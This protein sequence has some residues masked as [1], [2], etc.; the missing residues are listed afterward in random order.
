MIKETVLFLAL[1]AAS[2]CSQAFDW[3][4]PEITGRLWK[5]SKSGQ[6]DSY[7]LGTMHVGKTGSTLPPAVES[8]LKQSDLL[9]SEVELP[10]AADSAASEDMRNMQRE[11]FG[12]GGKTLSKHIGSSRTHALKTRW[13][14]RADT[15]AVLPHIE[16]LKP[17]AALLW[18]M[19]VRPAG[20]Q[21]E[22][23]LDFLLGQ[24]ALRLNIRRAGLERYTDLPQ[25]FKKLPLARIIEQLDLTEKYRREEEALQLEAVRLYEQKRYPEM[26]RLLGDTGRYRRYGVPGHTAAFW[27]NWFEHNIL[28]ARNRKW[29]PKILGSLPGQK[30]LIAVGSAH[31]AGQSGLIFQLRKHGYTVTPVAE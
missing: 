19:N 26:L 28:T 23:G 5:I 8:V 10:P 20:Y 27:Q 17:W 30:T 22:Y 15:R 29:L 25:S 6:P 11:M 16:Q 12:N 31:L 13:A 2:A 3:Q 7:L 14:E 18:D 21:A 9:L 24:A 4:T 1:L